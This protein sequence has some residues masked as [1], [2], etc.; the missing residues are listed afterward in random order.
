MMDQRNEH[1]KLKIQSFVESLPG[2]RT[3]EINQADMKCE[4]NL[5]VFAWWLEDSVPGGGPELAIRFP[6]VERDELIATYPERYHVPSA[7]SWKAWLGVR[8]Q[9]GIASSPELERLLRQAYCSV[10]PASLKKQLSAVE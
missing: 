6:L 5:K 1:V 3:I 7:K 2:V 4:V 10:A 9:P 8:I